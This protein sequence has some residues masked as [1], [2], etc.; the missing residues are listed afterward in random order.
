MK[1]FRFLKFYSPPEDGGGAAVA[2]PEMQASG[3]DIG[4]PLESPMTLYKRSLAQQQGQDPAPEPA[5][6]EPVAEPEPKAEVPKEPVKEEPKAPESALDAVFDTPPAKPEEVQ[7]EASQEP[8]LPETL[9]T[10]KAQRSEHWERA[11]NQIKRQDGVIRELNDKLKLAPTELQTKLEE[12]TKRAEELQ[13]LNDEYKDSMV[14]L[15]VEYEPEYRKKFVEGRD[16]LVGK[17]A[18][19]LNAF[20]GKGELIVEAMKMPE[21]RART[22]AINEALSELDEGERFRVREFVSQVER[23]D[24]ER[25][26]LQ[27]DPQTAWEKLKATESARQKQAA[28]EAENYKKRIFD[29]TVQKIPES[30][31]LLREVDPKLNGAEQHNANREKIIAGAWRLLG[32]GVTP[33]EL[34]EKAFKAEAYDFAQPLLVSTRKELREALARLAEYENA[35]PTFRGG[36]PQPKP[37]HEQKMEKTPGQLYVESMRGQGGYDE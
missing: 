17:A 16:M 1:T 5:K 23:L 21:S 34:A 35:E 29:E 12:A 36:K 9:P 3:A 11:R 18:A 10:D 4:P 25:A 27:K 8:E 33:Q 30:V 19:K 15:N 37:E 31:L 6:A 32:S 14:A 28:A 7:P 20:G 2:A 26:D 13:K 24:D 22:V